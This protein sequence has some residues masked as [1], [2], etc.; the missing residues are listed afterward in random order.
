M[1]KTDRLKWGY[2]L[3]YRS[4]RHMRKMRT[5]HRR[6]CDV[7]H[8]MSDLCGE[9]HKIVVRLLLVVVII[10]FKRQGIL[11]LHGETQH[12]PQQNI[13]PVGLLLFFLRS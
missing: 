1:Y 3:L 11:L 9:R 5:L 7:V 6:G 12:L 10:F 13:Q 4:F 8:E 2:Q